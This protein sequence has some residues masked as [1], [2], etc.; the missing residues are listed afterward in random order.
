MA[1]ASEDQGVAMTETDPPSPAPTLRS[2]AP[3][4]AESEARHRLQKDGNVWC[5]TGQH[6]V[7]PGECTSWRKKGKELADGK[8]YFR[9]HGCGARSKREADVLAC[10]DAAGRKKMKSMNKQARAELLAKHSNLIASEV[11][12]SL[13]NEISEGD[14]TKSMSGTYNDGLPYDSDD[15]EEKYGK[16]PNGANKI[17]AIKKNCK[18][19]WNKETE[20][21]NYIVHKMSTKDMQEDEH[22]EGSKR[23]IEQRD[24]KFRKADKPSKDNIVKTKPLTAPQKKKLAKMSEKLQEC[25]DQSRKLIATIDKKPDFEAFIPPAVLNNFKDNAAKVLAES[26]AIELPMREGWA[27]EFQAVYDVA[28]EAASSF[29]TAHARMETFMTEYS[30]MFGDSA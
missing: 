27:G 26:Y 17:A 16:R 7:D 9:C 20:C 23:T 14:H 19:T 3:S 18:K 12:A 6:W 25:K 4:I 21:W 15:L 30:K 5:G 22:T 13:K 8:V 28:E 24:D 2:N 11:A 1:G 10:C 29:S